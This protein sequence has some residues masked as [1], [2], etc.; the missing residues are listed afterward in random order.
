[1]GS[2]VPA[3][4]SAP[5]TEAHHMHVGWGRGG[6]DAEAI[7][8]CCRL[9]RC[10][11]G[12]RTQRARTLAAW[13]KSRPEISELLHP[14][15]RRLARARALARA[16]RQ[17]TARGPVR[18]PGRQQRGCSRSFSTSVTAWRKTTPSADALSCSCSGFVGLRT[19][20]L[21]C[22]T[23]S[24]RC[25]APAASWPHKGVM[26][27]FRWVSKRGRPARGP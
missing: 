7:L 1:M 13:L 5:A 3:T 15:L 10:A 27:R 22:P 4:K 6:N 24:R 18:L 21:S 17:A 20:S 8:R 23:T 16:L 26:V 9:C 2:I 25:A 12:R 19:G 14:A 11:T